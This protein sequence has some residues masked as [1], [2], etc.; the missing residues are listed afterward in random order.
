MWQHLQHYR[1]V[2]GHG[3][4][5]FDSRSLRGDFSGSSHT[6][7]RKIGTPVPTLPGA[8]VIGSTLG[9]VGSVSVYCDLMREK[10][11][12]QLLSQYCY[13]LSRSVPETQSHVAGTLSN[14][15]NNVPD[16]LQ[17]RRM[18]NS[19]PA[20]QRLPA[21]ETWPTVAICT[22]VCSVGATWTM[23]VFAMCSA[24]AHRKHTL[25][26]DVERFVSL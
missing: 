20:N 3:K 9:L 22:A 11:V 1:S 4:P 7:D 23:C 5:G 26:T 17:R 8:G 15:Q 18:K 14:E 16:Q 13:C 21:T 25:Y 19:Q 10:K 24:I 2:P 6:S 12:L